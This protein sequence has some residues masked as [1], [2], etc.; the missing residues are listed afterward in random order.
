MQT[1][2]YLYH[3][4]ITGSFFL[5]N[6]KSHVRLCEL[7][8]SLGR[9]GRRVRSGSSP[10]DSHLPGLPQGRQDPGPE[11]FR[12]AMEGLACG[13]IT[14]EELVDRDD[15]AKLPGGRD[16][17]VEAVSPFAGLPPVDQT[18]TALGEPLAQIYNHV[19]S[20]WNTHA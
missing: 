13:V 18:R 1:H 3:I 7:E 16:V 17:L 8:T 10:K 14:L 11:D 9:D 12:E 2:D 6:A 4:A 5:N 20:G 15:G 19:R